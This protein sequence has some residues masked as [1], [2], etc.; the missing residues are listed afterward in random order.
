MCDNLLAW[1]SA[2]LFTEEAARM[3]VA[4]S[5]VAISVFHVLRVA[6]DRELS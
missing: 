5:R 2:R 1:K 6:P 3:R 4:Y